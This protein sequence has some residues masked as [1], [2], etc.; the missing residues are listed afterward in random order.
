MASNQERKDK[1]SRLR[2]QLDPVKSAMVD[3]LRA[4][5]SVISSGKSEEEIQANSL[6]F[7]GQFLTKAG[8]ANREKLQDLVNEI[9]SDFKQIENNSVTP[10]LWSHFV[11]V[12]GDTSGF[13]S[14]NSLIQP[15]SLIDLYSYLNS[16]SV[17]LQDEI[18]QIEEKI[19]K[20]SKEQKAEL[21]SDAAAIGASQ[22]PPPPETSEAERREA[23]KQGIKD[24]KHEALEKAKK[25]YLSHRA[26][27]LRINDLIESGQLEK[28]DLD[29]LEKIASDASLTDVD[30][31]LV[32]AGIPKIVQLKSLNPL[33]YLAVKNLAE[34]LRYKNLQL[35]KTEG[36][37]TNL[38]PASQM[39][40]TVSELSKSFSPRAV[41]LAYS[42][43]GEQLAK[44]ESADQSDVDV[45]LAREIR[46]QSMG[47]IWNPDSGAKRL[48]KGFTGQTKRE[49]DA[50]LK[51][52]GLAGEV[53]EID[54]P[55]L[56]EEIL[57]NRSLLEV[58]G[59]APEEQILSYAPGEEVPQPEQTPQ[60]QSLPPTTR[61]PQDIQKRAET[62]KTLSTV[63]R[64]LAANPAAIGAGIA[65][66]G[67]GTFVAGIFAQAPGVMAVGGG[68]MGGVAGAVAGAAAGAGFL[69]IGAIP[70]AIIGGVIGT[71]GGGGAAYA[72]GQS[73]FGGPLVSLPVGIT[74]PT[75]GAVLG[76][77]GAGITPTAAAG[78]SGVASGASSVA[79]QGLGATQTF[80]SSL[81]SLPNAL[82]GI[83]ASGAIIVGPLA[84]AGFITAA[85]IVPSLMSSFLGPEEGLILESKYVT[86]EKTA[87]PDQPQPNS[88][89]STT[90]TVSYKIV[91]KP[92]HVDG[93][94]TK[95]LY[96]IEVT[97]AS[98]TYTISSKNGGLRAPDPTDATAL[99]GVLPPEGKEVTYEIPVNE[100]FADTLITNVV[101]LSFNITGPIPLSG[102]KT[103]GEARVTFGNPP[104][105]SDVGCW[106]FMPGG[107][108]G[109]ACNGAITTKDWSDKE[110]Q[111]F[112]EAFGATAKYS[113]YRNLLCSKGKVPAYRA[114]SDTYGGCADVRINGQYTG[115][116]AFYDLGLGSLQNSRYTIVHE[117]GHIIDNF[118]T[119][120]GMYK[121]FLAE[122]A[123]KE[124]KLASYGYG[125]RCPTCEDFAET[126]AVFTTYRNRIMPAVGRK[127][128]MP[129]E[130][131]IH[132]NWIKTNAFDNLE[133]P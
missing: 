23:E 121:R 37:S 115:G 93:N 29:N 125:S 61:T 41:T 25:A 15:N 101:N 130:Y 118:T 100:S 119:G 27:L 127:I 47:K 75:P 14:E 36:L 84:A 2:E 7:F 42:A 39:Q 52:L 65:A 92:K 24:R 129:T 57:G 69:G 111:L 1:Y 35:R 72:I 18:I 112:G 38:F 6:K 131:P 97:E 122:V 104:I 120:A 114:E 108:T 10:G 106:E 53:I 16:I 74:L 96:T 79:S 94:P 20:E 87:V 64:T 126:F 60:L 34:D 3:L 81:Q 66:A 22:Q 91:V 105:L 13:F 107:E 77:A 71:I 49:Q 44:M 17:G 128:D 54:R 95:P 30:I 33:A 58:L 109:V 113:T 124:A 12:N 116:V 26:K 89:L 63:G 102:Q 59:E 28:I 132:Y 21:S 56:F 43:S 85:I 99:V 103:S 68:M 9:H 78:A 5:R 70:G 83:P 8:L 19:Q 123:G 90:K 4:V 76:T 45:K 62:L 51:A 31:E 46:S 73:A 11:D 32:L 133:E 82:S 110:K 80:L 48:I 55:A 88:A 50:L 117:S 67:A 98:D 40:G 86:I